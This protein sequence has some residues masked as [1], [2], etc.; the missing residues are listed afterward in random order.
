MRAP[1]GGGYETVAPIASAGGARPEPARPLR[2][3]T[4]RLSA[5]VVILTRDSE[6]V[7]ERSLPAIREAARMAGAD[8]LFVDFGSTDGTRAF[9]ARHAPGARGVWLDAGDGFAEG[10]MAVAA[11][12]D[13]DVLVLMIQPARDVRRARRGGHGGVRVLGPNGTVVR[14]TRPEP[15]SSITRPGTSAAS[16]AS[17][18]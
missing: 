18:G 10:L 12:S 14:S 4:E 1:A 3:R 15:R 6:T 9:A 7:L 17:R 13:T 11:C 5:E 16:A 8:I 2:A